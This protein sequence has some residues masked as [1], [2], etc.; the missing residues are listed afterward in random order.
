MGAA[1]LVEDVDG[2]FAGED[3]GKAL[4]TF[5]AGEEDGFD[6]LVKN[7]AV[8]EEDGAKGL[9]LGGC[10]NVAFDGEVG[11]EGADFGCAHF[12]RM[13]FVVKED[14]A[15]RPVNVDFLGAVGVMFGTQGIRQLIEQFFCHRN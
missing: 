7:F 3:G 14:I 1:E 10:G 8:E 5:G 6:F 15:P 9:V 12:C 11:E 13:F 2:F 4:G